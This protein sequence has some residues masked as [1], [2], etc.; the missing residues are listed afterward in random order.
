MIINIT[1]VAKIIMIDIAL[2]Q[3][4]IV[5]AM[6][7]GTWDLFKSAF[8]DSDQISKNWL[9][10]FNETNGWFNEKYPNKYGLKHN[11]F[12]DYSIVEKSI[13]RSCLFG[14]KVDVLE[15]EKISK[16]KD[17]ETPVLVVE[18]YLRKLRKNLSVHRDFAWLFKEI[19]HR[20]ETTEI[21]QCVSEISKGFQN[22]LDR[23]EMNDQPNISFK[24]RNTD[25]T[26]KHSLVNPEF[27][28][29]ITM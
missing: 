14:D 18:E 20:S 10:G 24:E 13:Y 3:T 16:E 15:I 6:G 11:R 8:P 28:K 23:Y 7:S 22:F 27:P 5:G 19:D 2:L 12:F 29:I 21:L 1:T 9:Y 26:I 25:A 17:C 4:I